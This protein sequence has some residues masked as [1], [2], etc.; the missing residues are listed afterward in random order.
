[1]DRH[2]LYHITWRSLRPKKREKRWCHNKG[3]SLPNPVWQLPQAFSVTWPGVVFQ[4]FPASMQCF[5]NIIHKSSTP[6][7]LMYFFPPTIIDFHR[8]QYSILPT[9][10]KEKR[11][12]SENPL[13]CVLYQMTVNMKQNRLIWRIQTSQLL[14]YLFF[15]CLKPK[16]SHGSTQLKLTLTQLM[17]LIGQ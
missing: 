4:S 15:L 3:G 12:T 5:R 6:S 10:I 13:D 14:Y 1:M 7:H 9:K 8:G 16:K 2:A 11:S 17:A